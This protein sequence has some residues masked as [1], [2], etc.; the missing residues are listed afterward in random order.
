YIDKHR[1]DYLGNFEAKISDMHEDYIK[2]QENSSHYGCKHVTVSDGTTKVTFKHDEGLSFNASEY[3]QEELSTKRHNYELEK[4]G[5]TVFCVD[6][7]MA[8]VG[9]NSCGP[10]LK[11][12]YRVPLPKLSADFCMTIS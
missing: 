10:Q 8:G 9:S 6:A 5:Y 3:T 11:E 2:P 12:R 4:S 7:Y 1:A